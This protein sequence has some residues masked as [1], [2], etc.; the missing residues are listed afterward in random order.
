MSKPAAE[1]VSISEA[2]AREIEKVQLLKPFSDNRPWDE[3]LITAE[4]QAL[5]R[6][7]EISAIEIGKR[8]VFARNNVEEGRWGQFLNNS[9]IHE[10]TAQVYMR[11]ARTLADRPKVLQ[12][13][14]GR[15]KL[16]IFASLDP[17]DLEDFE[18]SGTLLGKDA[19]ELATLTREELK[20]LARDQKRRLEQAKEQVKEL[21]QKAAPAKTEDEQIAWLAWMQRDTFR[22]ID[23]KMKEIKELKGLVALYCALNVISLECARRMRELEDNPEFGGLLNMMSRGYSPE[24][25]RQMSLADYADEAVAELGLDSNQEN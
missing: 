20:K 3:T 15:E 7:N 25:A 12:I 16:N 18:R 22:N 2:R 23:A 10:R 9:G 1:T 11:I 21:E 13:A 17:A 4:L 5:A 6:I 14:S 24:L 19:D 8:L